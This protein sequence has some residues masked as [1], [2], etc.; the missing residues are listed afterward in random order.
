M[1]ARVRPRPRLR[2]GIPVLRRPGGVQ[3]GF[4]SPGATVISG[5]GP[6]L[7]RWLTLLDGTRG[8]SELHR[9]GARLDLD[10]DHLRR[11]LERLAVSG[12]LSDDPDGAT[13]RWRVRLIGAGR[14]GRA[15]ARL[16]VSADLAEI[17]LV[18]DDPVDRTLYPGSAVGRQAMALHAELTADRCRAARGEGN[19]PHPARSHQ[20][21]T[22]QSRPVRISAGSPWS[23]ISSATDHRT[24]S[25]LLATPDITVVASDRLDV[26]RMLTDALLR[27]DQPHL[28][29]RSTWDG[30]VVGPLV[31]PG[32]TPCVRC[33]D[34]VRCELDPDWPALLS[35]LCRTSGTASEPQLGWA[36]GVTVTQVLGALHALVDTERGWP[37]SAGATME[38]CRDSIQRRRSWPRHPS[39]GCGWIAGTAPTPGRVDADDQRA[40]G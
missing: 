7:A 10:P 18:D 16:L 22:Q 38:L 17:E 20:T 8:V 6:G 26:D 14:L 11:V 30:V 39:C 2:P 24:G 29:A 32:R 31:V 21:V 9:C 12:L 4:D 28:L 19:R 34:L 13:H 37:E 1:P 23:T 5:P 3:I 40:A 15:V 27:A 25:D 33:T 36:A 35:Q